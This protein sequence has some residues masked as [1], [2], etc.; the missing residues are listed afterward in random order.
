MS[1]DGYECSVCAAQ[2]EELDGWMNLDLKKFV[3]ADYVNCVPVQKD[4]ADCYVC[5]PDCAREALRR[6]LMK[7]E[8]TQ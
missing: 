4:L 7:Y 8:R 2:T 5:S 1:S 3:Q 6:A